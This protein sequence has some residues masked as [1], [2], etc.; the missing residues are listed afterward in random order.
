MCMRIRKMAMM[1]MI[2]VGGMAA[3]CGVWR[4]AGVMLSRVWQHQ[5]RQLNISNG[6]GVMSGISVSRQQTTAMSV[7]AAAHTNALCLM[8]LNGGSSA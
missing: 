6:S 2:Y 4:M 7:I 5:W 8:W 3:A 1:T